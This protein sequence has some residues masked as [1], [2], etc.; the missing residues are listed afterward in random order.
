MPISDECSE[1]IRLEIINRMRTDD[2]IWVGSFRH[3]NNSNVNH[4]RRLHII[5][6]NETKAVYC[7]NTQVARA[8]IK[9]MG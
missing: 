2:S 1:E 6:D 8:Y 3:F 7:R 5:K 4:I 9:P